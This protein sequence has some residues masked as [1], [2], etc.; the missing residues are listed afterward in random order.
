MSV[1]DT[2][3]RYVT[4]L[5]E[6]PR[7][8][9]RKN[10]E[11]MS[12]LRWSFYDAV[13]GTDRGYAVC[14]RAIY[15][16]RAMHK[17]RRE[18]TGN[19]R[20]KRAS[21]PYVRENST[22]WRTIGRRRSLLHHR[23]LARYSRE[24]SYTAP[25][26]TRIPPVGGKVRFLPRLEPYRSFRRWEITGNFQERRHENC[27]RT[28]ARGRPAIDYAETPDF[29]RGWPHAA[30]V[31]TRQSLRIHGPRMEGSELSPLFGR[32]CSCERLSK[33]ANGIPRCST[34]RAH[35]RRHKLFA[36]CCHGF[37]TFPASTPDYI[38]KCDRPVANVAAWSLMACRL[39]WAK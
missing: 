33:R 18:M 17:L 22:L 4:A 10:T 13:R 23:S 14:R 28:E 36:G 30:M 39:P 1:S 16:K 31:N 11:V 3:Q 7:K 27:P 35:V 15:E 19:L 12:T 8:L 9:F 37:R 21:Q 29:Q 20:A 25:D 24:R 6:P 2:L 26:G 38:W 34:H 5:S 32:L